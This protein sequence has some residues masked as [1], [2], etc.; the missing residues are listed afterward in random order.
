MKATW[1][2]LASVAWMFDRVCLLEGHKDGTFDPEEEAIEVGAN[3]VK[4]NENEF[5]FY[6]APE[7]LDE[8]RKALT[9]RGWKVTTAELS[10]KPKT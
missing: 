9:A 7:N 8:I 4:S 3:E 5:M 10:Y 6:G 1:A 2:S